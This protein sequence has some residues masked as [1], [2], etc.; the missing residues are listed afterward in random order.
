MHTLQ[1]KI[2]LVTGANRGIG[3]S[4]VKTALDKGAAKVYATG[5]DLS[6]M[7]DFEDEKVIHFELDI[8][9]SAQISTVV[10]ETE[11]TQV[12]I[13]N[14]GILSPGSILDG[15]MDAIRKDMDVNYYGTINMMRTYAPILERNAPAILVNIASIVA[16]SPLA[17]IAGYSASKGALYSATLSVRTELAKKGITVHAVNPGAID[18]DMNKGSDWE[19]PTADITAGII[20]DQV[21][22]KE[23]DIIPDDRGL[24]MHQAWRED[25]KKLAEVFHDL[26]H[27]VES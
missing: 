8:A 7:P 26:Y 17:S 23:L 14:A 16:Y 6:K 20:L 25:P 13:N 22:L 5:R 10:K 1:D 19:M 24:G 4:L 21:E 11:D 12:L 2:I 3:K 15:D 18:T 27:G 9:N